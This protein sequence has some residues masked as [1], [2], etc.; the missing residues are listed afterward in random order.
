M[1]FWFEQV[2]L[3]KQFS[4][5]RFYQNGSSNAF[6]IL[7]PAKLGVKSSVKMC[8]DRIL[9]TSSIEPL[10]E[11]KRENYRSF[12]SLKCSHQGTDYASEA[13]SD[14]SM[15]FVITYKL[16]LSVLMFISFRAGWIH[17]TNPRVLR[18]MNCSLLYFNILN[19]R[20]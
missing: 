15:F 1:G 8:A 20:C 10:G 19:H 16:I 4:K 18:I 14:H 13:L 3:E 7:N 11:L 5:C 17:V 9:V 12:F 2:K 6:V